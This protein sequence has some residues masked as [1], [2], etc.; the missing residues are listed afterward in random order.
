ML[1]DLSKQQN[2][3]DLDL[4][5][6]QQVR[7]F[8]R[9]KLIEQLQTGNDN[10]TEKDEIFYLSLLLPSILI[11]LLINNTPFHLKFNLIVIASK[12]E[13]NPTSDV[14]NSSKCN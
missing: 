7:E 8:E 12:F 11:A 13:H 9:F 3:F 2:K 14:R 4:A 6:L 10:A 1:N 5:K